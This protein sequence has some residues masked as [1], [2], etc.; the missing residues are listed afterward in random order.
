[1]KKELLAKLR[2]KNEAYGGWEQGQVSWEKYRYTV[3]THRDSVRKTETHLELNL[4]SKIKSKRRA[5]VS[6]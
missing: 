2:H 4:A 5:S 6:A 3:Q 1:M